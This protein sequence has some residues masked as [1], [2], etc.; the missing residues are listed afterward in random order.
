M[1]LKTLPLKLS[2]WFKKPWLNNVLGCP[3]SLLRKNAPL[4]EPFT[5]MIAEANA[6]LRTL[7]LNGFVYELVRASLKSRASA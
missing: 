4:F 2:D 3:S 1:V 5:S 6:G 7:P